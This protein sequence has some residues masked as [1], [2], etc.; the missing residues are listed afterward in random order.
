MELK[1]SD[2]TKNSFYYLYN[3]QTR[4]LKGVQGFNTNIFLLGS[5]DLGGGNENTNVLKLVSSGTS[6]GLHWGKKFGSIA[7]DSQEAQDF[8]L[9]DDNLFIALQSDGAGLN[10]P[11]AATNPLVMKSD[12]EFNLKWGYGYGIDVATNIVTKLETSY[13]K[14]AVFACFN[15]EATHKYG[16]IS[17]NTYNGILIKATKI[18]TNNAADTV[19]GIA[20]RNNG[21]I[22][23]VGKT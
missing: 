2:L 13:D 8:I 11:A 7:G 21:Y 9:R 5:T 18:G 1:A 19:M 16:L 4:I 22:T 17:I 3:L 15:S 6:L 20:L 12:L 14:S 23:L 10:V